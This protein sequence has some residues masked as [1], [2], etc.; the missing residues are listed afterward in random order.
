[1]QHR[2]AQTHSRASQKFKANEE[3]PSIDLHTILPV[4]F[5]TVLC[6]KARYYYTPL[7]RVDVKQAHTRRKLYAHHELYC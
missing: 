6:A 2:T 4:H 5:I 1:M 3:R 7:S